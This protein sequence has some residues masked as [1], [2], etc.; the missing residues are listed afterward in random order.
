MTIV[1]VVVQ[2]IGISDTVAIRSHISRIHPTS[3]AES[4]AP[5]GLV[6]L[7]RDQIESDSRFGE[8]TWK[9]EGIECLHPSYHAR[10][11]RW[12]SEIDGICLTEELSR[13]QAFSAD[14]GLIMERAKLFCTT[15]SG[16]LS[17]WRSTLNTVLTLL[18][19]GCTVSL[20]QICVC[21]WI[22]LTR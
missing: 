13:R 15:F 11:S 7:M 20:F 8:C 18:C 21:I 12:K 4:G 19:V 10:L 6:Y 5:L 1:L 14:H 22:T 16:V 9:S 2:V 17:S 3:I